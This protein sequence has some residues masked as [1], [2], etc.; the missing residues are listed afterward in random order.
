MTAYDVPNRFTI[1]DTTGTVVANSPWMGYATYNGP[2]GMSLN[3]PTSG[4]LYFTKTG[5][6]TYTMRVETSVSGTSDSYNVSIACTAPSS[7]IRSFAGVSLTY[8]QST[9]LIR[10]NSESDLSRVLDTLDASYET[11][12]ANYENQYSS[13]TS[14]QL[15]SVDAITS[16]DEF[17]SMRQFEGLFPS[18]TSKRSQLEGIENIWLT[19]NMTGIDP[20]SVDQTFDDAENVVSNANNKLIVGTTTYIFGD[21][22]TNDVGARMA[23]TASL[24]TGSAASTLS[25]LPC[26]T[27]RRKHV[28][29]PLPDGSRMFKLKVAINSWWVRSG[30]KGKV[31]SYKKQSSG[32]FKRSRMKLAVGCTGTIYDNHCIQSFTFADRNPSPSGF[33]NRKSLKVA[34]HQPGIIWKT[35]ANQLGSSFEALNV[36]TATLILQ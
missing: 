33:K 19:N 10:F 17:Y 25:S 13:L 18:Y 2:W 9:G 30:A 24:R 20:D 12:N 28:F 31:V 1:Y 29:Y 22:G 14:D 21:A 15:D 26:F 23:S 5:S 36:A 7:V 16:F 32:K 27:N 35:E 6:G 3:S 11:Y 34:R 4:I 8:Y